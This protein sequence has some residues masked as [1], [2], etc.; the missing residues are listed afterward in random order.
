MGITKSEEKKQFD[1][2]YRNI[3][4]HYGEKI[5]KQKLLD[6]TLEELKILKK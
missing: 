1:R 2:L 6:M 3:L 4:K 5:D